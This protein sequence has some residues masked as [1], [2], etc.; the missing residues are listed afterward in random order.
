MNSQEKLPFYEISDYPESYSQ[1]A[2]V[3]RMIDGLGFRYYWATEGLTDKDLNFRL[4]NESRSSYETI[5]HIYD[6]SKM[7]L[8]TALNLPIDMNP[9]E[10]ME[11][12][13]A[14][15]NTLN[16]LKKASEILAKK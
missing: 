8:N 2:M 7:I 11:F 10:G 1:A 13:E 4:P 6:L 15:E 12:K 5:I 9:N 14:R 3:G 16:N